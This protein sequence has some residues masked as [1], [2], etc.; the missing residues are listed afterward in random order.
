ML[1]WS[2]TC[3]RRCLWPVPGTVVAWD[4]D[5]QMPSIAKAGN[6]VSRDPL[7]SLVFNSN[8]HGDFFSHQIRETTKLI[9]CL[10]NGEELLP[11]VGGA[12]AFPVRAA[13]AVR[14]TLGVGVGGGLN[15]RLTR[16]AGFS[17]LNFEISHLA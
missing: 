6:W 7:L 11:G 8:Y 14:R 12:L 10:A 3:L 17:H 15:K 2:I 9:V 1:L 13:P 16:F 5:V 4:D